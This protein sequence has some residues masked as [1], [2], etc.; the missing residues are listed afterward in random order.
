[1]RSGGRTSPTLPTS[2]VLGH[3]VK[4]GSL[5]LAPSCCPLSPRSSLCPTLLGRLRNLHLAP[6]GGSLPR[7]SLSVLPY[8]T[9]AVSL[10]SG[11]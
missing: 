7:S 11:S 10:P 3:V 5:S 9:Q 8:P 2:E 1:M 6:E 4:L